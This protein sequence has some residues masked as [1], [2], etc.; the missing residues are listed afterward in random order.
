MTRVEILL[1]E[2]THETATTRKHLER[3]PAGQFEWRPHQKSY[4]SAGFAHR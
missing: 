4:W 1:L 3:V 2:F